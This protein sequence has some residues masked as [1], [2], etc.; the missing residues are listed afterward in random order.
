MKV[1]VIWNPLH[2]RVVCVHSSEELECK[3]C[4]E[5]SEKIKDTAYS[6]GGEWFEVDSDDKLCY[7]G[8]P[9]DTTNPDCVEYDLCINCKQDLETK[10]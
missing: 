7:C 2:E 8:N 6:L 3:N 5:E 9:V 10:N 4:I 1:Y